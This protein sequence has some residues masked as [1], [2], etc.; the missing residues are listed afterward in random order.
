MPKIKIQSV[1]DGGFKMSS[2]NNYYNMFI[3]FSLR[4]TL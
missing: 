4:E 3:Y 1:Y 2:K